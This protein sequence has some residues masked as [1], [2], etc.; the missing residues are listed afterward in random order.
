MVTEDRRQ[1]NR[2]MVTED[3]RQN[4]KCW[5]LRTDVRTTGDGH[6]GQTSGQQVMV[7]LR[8]DGEGSLGTGMTCE[9]FQLA[10]MCPESNATRNS[11]V[12]TGARES[13]Q[14]L[15]KA[16]GTSSGPHALRWFTCL[17]CRFASFSV[18]EFRSCVKVEVDVLGSRPQ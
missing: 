7:I 16:P 17:K 18:P 8:T 9:D 2:V 15:R 5:S 13:G 14:C 6:W 12:N 10:G 4:N 3:R 11:L 1:D